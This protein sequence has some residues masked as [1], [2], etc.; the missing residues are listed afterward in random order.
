M[1]QDRIGRNARREF[2][3]GV[4]RTTRVSAVMFG[5]ML[6]M[7]GFG[8]QSAVGRGELSLPVVILIYLVCGVTG[9]ILAG[10]ARMLSVSRIASFLEDFFAIVPFGVT[11]AVLFIP[12]V[13]MGARALFGAFATLLYSLFAEALSLYA[14]R[15]AA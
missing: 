15:R 7:L 3:L 11:I 10:V 6:F 8:K 2:I 4:R 12:H 9:S 13:S 14:R 1:R 5:L